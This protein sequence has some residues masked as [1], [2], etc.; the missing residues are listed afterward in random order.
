MILNSA[1][2]FHKKNNKPDAESNLNVGFAGKRSCRS[3]KTYNYRVSH[4]E[5]LLTGQLKLTRTNHRV[6]TTFWRIGLI[7][8]PKRP[9]T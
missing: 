2:R 6:G 3:A 7:D 4:S 9:E 8:Q 5:A 1:C